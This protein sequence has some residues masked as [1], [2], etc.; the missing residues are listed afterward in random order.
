MLPPTERFGL[1][2]RRGLMR[3]G[4]PILNFEPPIESRVLPIA[5]MGTLLYKMSIPC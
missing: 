1:I 5:N 3:F 2:R 4:G